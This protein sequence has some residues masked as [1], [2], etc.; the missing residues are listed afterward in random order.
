MRLRVDLKIFIFLLIFYLTK[1]IKIYEY[2]MIFCMIHELGH[3]LAGIF[4]KL[5]PEKIDIMPFGLSVQFKLFPDDYNNKVL[6]SNQLQIKKI[7][8]AMAGPITNFVLIIAAYFMKL[9][10]EVKSIIIYSNMI[11]ALFN[12][13]PIYPLDGGRILKG[14]LNIM[15]GRKRTEKIMN[16]VSNILIVFITMICAFLVYVLKNIAIIV[17]LVYLW[18]LIINEN[19]RYR[20]KEKIYKIVEENN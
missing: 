7:I 10:I 6:K 3:I 17:S 12:L 2:I 20:T 14:I 4:L 8:I 9:S 13:L 15:Y 5:K 19:K 18:F 16:K 11:I 1:Q